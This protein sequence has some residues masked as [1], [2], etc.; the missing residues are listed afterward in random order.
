[1]IFFYD[2]T[3]LNIVKQL[4]VKGTHSHHIIL[5]VLVNN[6]FLN[7]TSKKYFCLRTS[8]YHFWWLIMFILIHCMFILIMRTILSN[9]WRSSWLVNMGMNWCYFTWKF[10]PR[11]YIGS[12]GNLNSINAACPK[13]AMLST[14]LTHSE[15]S[16]FYTIKNKYWNSLT[17]ISWYSFSQSTKKVG[18]GPGLFHQ[19]G[20]SSVIRCYP[21]F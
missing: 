2:G 15:R 12:L 19:V 17:R 6:T 18:L 16:L 7:G 13:E 8:D 10:E 11:W 3:C 1:M 21:I 9:F 20:N 14:F 5:C 4:H